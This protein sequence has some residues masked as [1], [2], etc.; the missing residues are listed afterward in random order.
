MYRTF[1]SLGCGTWVWVCEPR[2]VADVEDADAAEA[3]GVDLALGVADA[4]I[5]PGAVLLDRHEQQIPVHRDVALTARADHRQHQLR[6]AV[7]AHVIGVEAVEIADEQPPVRHRHVAVGEG[8]RTV[9]RARRGLR[10]AG[11]DGRR[12]GSRRLGLLAGRRG[13][14]GL[15]IEEAGRRP[16]RMLQREVRDRLSGVVQPGRQGGADVR[17]HRGRLARGRGLGLDRRR[18]EQDAGRRGGAQQKAADGHGR[19]SM[20]GFT[21]RTRRT[22]CAGSRPPG[23][24]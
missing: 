20:D 8:Q 15:G 11:R 23:R 5:Q 22:A 2:Q 12:P 17:P 1:G 13:E 9:A 3:L 18:P 14:N 4:A 7:T 21:A 6:R 10:R 16:H 19:P 24:R